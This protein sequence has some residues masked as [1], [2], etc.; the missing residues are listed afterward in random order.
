MVEQS[1]WNDEIGLVTYFVGWYLS[2]PWLVCS[3]QESVECRTNYAD[4][5]LATGL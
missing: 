3:A 4:D 1:M 2:R 5:Y